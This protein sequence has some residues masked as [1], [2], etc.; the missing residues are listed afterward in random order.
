MKLRTFLLIFVTSIF[1]ISC[2]IPGKGSTP[3]HAVQQPQTQPV[4]AQSPQKTLPHAW[5]YFSGSSFFQIDAPNNAPQILKKPWT[6]SVR[7]SSSLSIKNES[8]DYDVYF[9]VNRAGLLIAKPT[10][11][12]KAILAGDIQLFSK[13]TA[14]SLVCVDGFPVFHTYKNSFFSGKDKTI[15][16]LPFLVQFHP[17]TSIFLPLLYTKDLKIMDD[18]QVTDV[19]YTA[20]VWVASLKTETND[21]TKFDYLNFFS[22][23]PLV[24]FSP[25]KR[26]IV[27]ETKKLSVGEYRKLLTPSSFTSAPARLKEL[28]KRL[29]A[30]FPFYTSVTLPNGG[31]AVTYL[32]GSAENDKTFPSQALLS[33]TFSLAVFSDGTCFFAGALPNNH[34]LSNGEPVAFRLPKLPISF[35]YGNIGVSGT[36]LYVS[37]EEGTFYETGRSGFLTVDLKE[38]LY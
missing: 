37:W 19:Q 35:T 8:K 22:Y 23:E 5:F 6:E 26:N 11:P 16:S 9:T 34:I 29:P 28:Y 30:G 31:S 38:I 36:T 33:E 18:A 13:L 25:A 20:G 3:A 15:E 27:L 7:I 24:Q 21:K 32:S 1:F 12:K 17:G 10:L 2:S 4:Q 14:G